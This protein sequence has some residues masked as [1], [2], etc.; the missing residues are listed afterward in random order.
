MYVLSVA[1]TLQLCAHTAV[2]T[3]NVHTQIATAD[4]RISNAVSMHIQEWNSLLW[5]DPITSPLDCRA[6]CPC[7]VGTNRRERDAQRTDRHALPF[8]RLKF[9][10]D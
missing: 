6:H 10:V 8:I 3:C 1:M 7:D 4:R 5:H 9:C 2:A